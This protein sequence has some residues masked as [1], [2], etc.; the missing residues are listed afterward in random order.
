MLGDASQDIGQ[1]GL[2]I[3]IGQFGGDDQA[4]DRRGPLSAAIGPGEQP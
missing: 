2:R 1:P 4:M 3:D